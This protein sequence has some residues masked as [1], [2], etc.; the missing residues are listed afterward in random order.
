MFW[1]TDPL[2]DWTYDGNMEPR[3][4]TVLISGTSDGGLQDFLRVMTRKSS[5][6]KIYEDLDLGGSGIRL[7][8]IH[9]LEHRFERA[10]AWQ[11]QGKPGTYP[12]SLD[13]YLSERHE[14]CRREVRLMLSRNFMKRI[15]SYL[16]LRPGKTILVSEFDHFPCAY[17]LNLILSLL[18]IEAL[19]L[20]PDSA[21]RDSV[22][23]RSPAKVTRLLDAGPTT[24]GQGLIAQ[25]CIGRP[26]DVVLNDDSVNPIRADVVVIRHGIRPTYPLSTTSVSTHSYP[27][28]MPPAHLF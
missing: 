2:E 27:R 1:E 17:I 21:V 12:F 9:S 8:R 23:V 19:R 10:S 26:W 7:D 25:Q 11:P 22:E 3:Q 5:A 13:S 15:H 16:S 4:E 6:R 14:R 18:V 20:H 24:Q 28:P